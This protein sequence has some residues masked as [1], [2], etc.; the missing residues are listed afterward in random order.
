MKLLDF[1][2]GTSDFE[3]IRSKN[4]E[5][6]DKTRM[7]S[8]ILHESSHIL[9]FARP[10]KF[11]K[12]LNL[13]MLKYFFDIRGDSRKLFEGLIIEKLPEFVH[14][15]Q[16]P[17][18]LISFDDMVFETLSEATSGL[19]AYFSK[20]YEDHL[21]LL[22]GLDDDDRK[23]FEKVRKGSASLFDLTHAPTLLMRF[24]KRHHKKNVI[25][26]LDS[27]D[28]LLYAA[29]AHGYMTKME[30]FIGSLMNQAFKDNSDLSRG[31][32]TGITGFSPQ[33]LVYGPNNVGSDSIL[34]N[35][36]AQYFGF[37]QEE[38]DVLLEKTG[39]PNNRQMIRDWYNGFKF[40]TCEIYNPWSIINYFSKGGE[41]NVYWVNTSDNDLVKQILAKSSSGLKAD[42][43]TLV[44]GGEIVRN[45][46][47]F[48]TLPE[49]FANEDVAFSLLLFSGYLKVTQK[50]IVDGAYRCTLQIQN[51]E[52]K[53]LFKKLL[54]SF[55]N[56]KTYSIDQYSALL[57]SL[58]TGDIALFEELLQDY[59]L[60]TFSYYDVTEKEP[61]RFYH[62]F[63][64]GLLVSLQNTHWVKSNKES[65]YGRYDVLIIPKDQTKYPLATIVEFKVVRKPEGLDQGIEIAFQKIEDQQYRIELEALG[66]SKIQTLAIVFCG[67]Q[68]KLV[69]R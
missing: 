60:A 29:Q 55:F 46:D 51:L 17:V 53:A 10:E 68:M 5:Y 34:S 54:K 26:L 24:L 39:Q 67:K 32:V 42:F 7:I 61:E 4:F 41:P 33:V 20:L 62:G 12:T 44:S 15:N 45:I 23:D 6:I 16:H 48:I 43:E 25:V 57:M 38:V 30:Y 3:E 13:S 64:L 27:Y 59:L 50:E 14:L 19:Q 52:I 65:G 69:A 1:P 2:I 58:V 63:V 11:G 47:E 56:I 36:Y 21:Y 40:G 22:S 8:E 31:V 18:L 35:K 49:L 66:I 37:T 9:S 28:T